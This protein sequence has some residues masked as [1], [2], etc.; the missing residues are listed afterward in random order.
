MWTWFAE[1]T[2]F[3]FSSR[4]RHTRLQGDWSSDVCSS[5]LGVDS[6]VAAALV[7]RA[8]GERLTCIFVDHGLLRLNERE[9]VERTF[10]AHLGIDL[11][12]VDAGERFL[13]ALA[14]VEDPEEKRR[15][16]GHTFIDVF[17][18]SE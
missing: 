16:I 4:R 14:G 17:E 11:R 8:M 12:V 5:D 18:R 3:F 7:H 15:R 9:Q 6:A 1:S 2:A 13:A 10:R